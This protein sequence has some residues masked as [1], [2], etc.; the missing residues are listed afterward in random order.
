MSKP[1]TFADFKPGTTLGEN[2][3]T[4]DASLVQAWQR[5]FGQ[6]PVDDAAEAASVAM[7]LSMRA[8]LEVVSPRPPGNVHAREQFSLASLPR[9]GEQVRNVISCVAKEI[10][11]ERF[12]VDL[13]VNGTGEGG[14]ALYSG[15]MSLI[16]AA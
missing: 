2:V 13:E 11:R 1:I 8:F 14:R 15:R 12:Y 4:Y 10:K 9:L 3:E 7:V 16:W 6:D 5:I